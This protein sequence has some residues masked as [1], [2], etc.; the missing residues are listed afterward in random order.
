MF[1]IE[2]RSWRAP[3][4][5]TVSRGWQSPASAQAYLLEAKARS[6]KQGEWGQWRVVNIC[7]GEPVYIIP[8]NYDLEKSKPMLDLEEEL[9]RLKNA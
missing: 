6:D 5:R 9:E 3:A 7:G 1:Q 8:E 4:W 2:Y